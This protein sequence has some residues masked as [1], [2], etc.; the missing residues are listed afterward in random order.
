MW[1]IIQ[2]K[3]KVLGM[4]HFSNRVSVARFS[5]LDCLHVRCK[6]YSQK[7]MFGYN[8]F[9]VNKPLLSK[10]IYI[11]H[12]CSHFE[13]SKWLYGCTIKS[14]SQFLW[15]REENTT[16]LN[17]FKVFREIKCSITDLLSTYP[18]WLVGWLLELGLYVLSQS[19]VESAITESTK[20]RRRWFFV[21]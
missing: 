19:W 18:N 9:Q 5:M 4:V 13:W 2:I 11:F 10:A 12:V 17:D 3:K 8:C 6:M 7:H 16:T 21:H 14:S 15:T 20:A 1:L